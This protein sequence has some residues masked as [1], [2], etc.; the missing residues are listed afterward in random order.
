MRV[1]VTGGTGFIGRYVAL[2]LARAGHDVAVLARNVS[3][4]PPELAGAKL[5]RGDLLDPAA[6]A[7]A[8]PGIEAVVHC[9]AAMDGNLADQRRTTVQGTEHLLAAMDAANVRRLV[10]VSS[11]AVY[12]HAGLPAWGVLDETCPLEEQFAARGP[13]IQAK[14]EQEDLIRRVVGREGWRWTLLRPGLVYGPGRTWFYHLGMQLSPVRWVCLAGASLLPL[15]WVEHCADAAALAL[16]REAAQG[17][18]LNIVDDDLPAR[19]DYVRALAALVRPRAS[20]LVV[21]WAPLA[22]AAG[23]CAGTV[24]RLGLPLPGILNPV[25]LAARCKPLRYS[26]AL[27]ARVLGWKPRRPWREALADAVAAADPD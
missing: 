17:Q 10:A 11:F 6:V 8:L 7:A 15:T 2:A 3:A 9:A 25:T 21:P 23:L 16:V 1:L 5:R 26:N 18:T 19:A 12:D 22:L 13:Y 14:R 4:P 24:G 20:V 27:A